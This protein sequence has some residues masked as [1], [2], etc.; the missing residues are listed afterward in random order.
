MIACIRASEP[1]IH[2]IPLGNR[3]MSGYK[4]MADTYRQL[5]D[6][7]KAPPPQGLHRHHCHA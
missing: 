5:W 1:F 6:N 7:V 2:V 3:F 4:M